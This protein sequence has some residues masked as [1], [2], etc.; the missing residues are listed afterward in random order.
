MPG[1]GVG[2]IVGQSL[3]YSLNVDAL[4]YLLGVVVVFLA[5]RELLRKPDVVRNIPLLPWTLAAGVVHGIFATGGPLLVYG[6]N[7]QRIE[8]AVF[9]STLTLVWGALATGL[10]IS[11]IASGLLTTAALPQIGMLAAI[12]PLSIIAGEWAHRYVNEALF[13]RVINILLVFCGIALL[14]K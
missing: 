1:M 5:G 3:F 14:L 4:K 12:L 7:G 6:L 10:V 2:M 13:K 11:Y 8:K 9:R